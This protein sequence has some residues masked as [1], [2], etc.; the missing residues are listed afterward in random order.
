M[1]KWEVTFLGQRKVSVSV[2]DNFF[3]IDRSI[4]RLLSLARPWHLL[5]S[6]LEAR[7]KTK[8]KVLITGLPTTVGEPRKDADPTRPW[9]FRARTVDC[10]RPLDSAAI[11]AQAILAQDGFKQPFHVLVTFVLQLVWRWA[12]S[13]SAKA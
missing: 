11:L 6:A 1:N 10:S 9:A 3:K 2:I 4:D 12:N 8:T 7:G 5:G 13:L